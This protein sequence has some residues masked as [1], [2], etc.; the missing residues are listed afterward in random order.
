M[1]SAR[2]S[3]FDAS[4]HTR[5]VLPVELCLTTCRG[6]GICAEILELRNMT[7]VER[8]QRDSLIHGRE[9]QLV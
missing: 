2:T 7:Y 9:S 6:S 1:H 3:V 4:Q 8:R 5:Q